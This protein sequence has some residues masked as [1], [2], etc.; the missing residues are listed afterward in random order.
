MHS[1]D[2]LCLASFCSDSRALCPRVPVS[3]KIG[4]QSF[5]SCE[6]EEKNKH[7]KNKGEYELIFTL[8]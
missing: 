6:L 7:H 3:C 4:Q 2:F 8:I 1:G 5:A